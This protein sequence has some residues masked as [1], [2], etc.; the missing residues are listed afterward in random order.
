MFVFPDVS[1]IT[2]VGMLAVT[3][4]QLVIP[5]T[6]NSKL[7]SLF[8]AICVGPDVTDHVVPD[9]VISDTINDAVSIGSSNITL[10]VA[11]STE[12]GSS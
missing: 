11:L 6:I 7:V 4:S 3:V 1:T 10:N 9:R 2:Q 12:V 8:G 5:V